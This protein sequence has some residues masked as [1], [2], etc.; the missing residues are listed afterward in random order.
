MNLLKFLNNHR[1]LFSASTI[2]FLGLSIVVAILPALDNQAN[3]APLPDATP[4]EG[5]AEAG[6]QVYIANGCVGC[7]TQQVRAAD[8]DKMW[9]KRPGIPAD[10]AMNT[11][12]DVWRNTATLMGTERTGPDLTNIGIRQPSKDWHLL[13]L[14]NPRAVVGK[15][16]MPAYPW[17]FEEKPRAYAGDVVVNVPAEWKRDSNNV[18]VATQEALNLV[19]YLLSLQQTPLP[20]G[21]PEPKFLFKPAPK[22]IAAAG[23]E[24]ASTFDGAALYSANCQSCHQA[25]G[26]G[27]KGAFP[28]LKG[29]KVVLDDENIELMVNIIMNGYNAR[30][31]YGVM[32]GIGTVNNLSAGEVTAIMNHEKN[33]WGNAAKKVAEA[34]VK[35]LMEKVKKPQ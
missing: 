25:N 27:L 15:S 2:L 1:L 10:Y 23:G 35:A 14:F 5:S 34:D 26:E 22:P 7:H 8:M 32:P 33:S 19:D 21:T 24:A 11:R 6:K 31:E 16:I 9:G 3:N 20:D 12:M 29:S 17:M 18:V 30:E 4:L 28:P 13:H